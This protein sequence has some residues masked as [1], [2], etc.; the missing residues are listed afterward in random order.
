MSIPSF[1]TL[2]AA[3]VICAR[4]LTFQRRGGRVRRGYSLLAWALIAGSGTMAIR[5]IAGQACGA[6][7]GIAVVMAV[8]ALLV[9]RAGGN[10]A[11]VITL[12]SL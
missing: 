12:R 2:I 3:I 5:I 1:M 6:G 8:F 10:I 4:L 9:I 11:H 7:W